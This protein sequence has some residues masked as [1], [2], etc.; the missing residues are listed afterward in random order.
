MCQCTED[1]ICDTCIETERRNNTTDGNDPAWVHFA[2][3]MQ[4]DL[5]SRA[6]WNGSAAFRAWARKAYRDLQALNLPESV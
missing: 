6:M 5:W 1:T 2:H 3:S 4:G